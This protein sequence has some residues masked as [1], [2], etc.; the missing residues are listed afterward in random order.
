MFVH[1]P[2]ILSALLM[3]HSRQFGWSQALSMLHVSAVKGSFSPV[4]FMAQGSQEQPA[5][6]PNTEQD[7]PRVKK[8]KGWQW[9]HPVRCRYG[10]LSGVLAENP[11]L[12]G[13]RQLGTPGN[14]KG[15]NLP[16][17][18]DVSLQHSWV[19]AV[20]GP[21]SEALLAVSSCDILH[22][23]EQLP[24]CR[25]HQGWQRVLCFHPA[26]APALSARGHAFALTWLTM[27]C[28][29]LEHRHVLLS[30][31]YFMSPFCGDTEG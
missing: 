10:S 4:L 14:R 30:P 13:F 29:H 2:Q 15:W 7:R 3:E 12:Q 5:K 23:P 18:E 24:T 8:Q 27:H 1:R 9:A 20:R 6:L 17:A 28:N 22:V 31:L 11:Q 25:S 19:T 16:K 26:A 21:R